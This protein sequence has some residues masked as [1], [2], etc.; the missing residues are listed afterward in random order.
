MSEYIIPCVASYFLGIS[1]MLIVIG[2]CMP[3][4]KADGKQVINKQ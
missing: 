4:E 1:T 2:L 3:A